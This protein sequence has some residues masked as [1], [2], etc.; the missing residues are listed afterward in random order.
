MFTHRLAYVVLMAFAIF[1]ILP[2]VV[3]EVIHVGIYLSGAE[4]FGRFISVFCVI[5]ILAIAH[6]IAAW[7]ANEK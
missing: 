4:W 1:Y 7:V 6:C 2:L 5:V 3:R